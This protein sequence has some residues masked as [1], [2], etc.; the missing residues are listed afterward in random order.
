MKIKV[1]RT[2]GGADIELPARAHSNDAGADVYTTF[3]E[4][5]KPHET[6]SIPLGFSL[7]LPDDVMAC[8]FPRSRMALEGLV[9]ELPPIGPGHTGEVHAIVT[10]LTD[11][12]K[13]VPGGTRIG[14]LV[15]MPVVPADFVEESG[16]EG[17]TAP[18]VPPAGPGEAAAGA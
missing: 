2:A 11:K 14:R 6:R 18:S 5:L 10:N 4:T 17:A 1:N 16:G 3:G 8:V 7:E 15:V 13:K 12:L 9:C